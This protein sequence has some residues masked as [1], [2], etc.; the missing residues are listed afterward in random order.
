MGPKPNDKC[1]YKRYKE[2]NTDRRGTNAVMEAEIAG[3]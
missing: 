1:S 2:E 3:M